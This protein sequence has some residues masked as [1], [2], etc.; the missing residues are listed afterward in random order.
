MKTVWNALFS[1]VFAIIMV[2]AIGAT[3]NSCHEGGIGDLIKNSNDSVQTEMSV[4]EYYSSM[5]SLSDVFVVKHDMLDNM[6]TD[7]VFLVIP[8]DVLSNVV[9][10]LLKKTPSFTKREL[11]N[12][13]MLNRQVYDNLPPPVAEVPINNTTPQSTPILSITQEGSTT[14]TEAPPTGVGKKT[15]SYSNKDTVID[16]KRTEIETKTT[17]YE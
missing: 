5:E 9:G 15:V 13:Y 8:D 2:F 7:S 10:V 11:V 3:V 14:V 6:Y 1:A 4:D 17:T 12:E 16:G